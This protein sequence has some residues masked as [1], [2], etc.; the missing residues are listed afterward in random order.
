LASETVKTVP[1][2]CSRAVLG[3]EITKSRNP[4]AFRQERCLESVDHFFQG[5]TCVP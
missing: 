4:L 1:F 5:A 3:S 2:S